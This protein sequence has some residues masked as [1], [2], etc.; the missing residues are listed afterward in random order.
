MGLQLAWEAWA[1]ATS[2][3]ALERFRWCLEAAVT[4]G[5]QETEGT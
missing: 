4:S 3:K 5:G 1:K 2:P